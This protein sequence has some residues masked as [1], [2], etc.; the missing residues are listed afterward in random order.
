M[1]RHKPEFACCHLKR[2]VRLAEPTKLCWG[3][4]EISQCV[5]HRMVTRAQQ[6]WFVTVR[7]KKISWSNSLLC[8]SSSMSYMCRYILSQIKSQRRSLF[9]IILWLRNVLNFMISLLD[10]VSQLCG[11]RK[12]FLLTHPILLVLMSVVLGSLMHTT[13]LITMFAICE[14]W[15]ILAKPF[16][17]S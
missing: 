2:C 14:H 8:A 15:L 17:Y 16:E 9:F 6:R 12:L 4:T 10:C 7:L 3:S 13:C 11:I 1:H 5:W